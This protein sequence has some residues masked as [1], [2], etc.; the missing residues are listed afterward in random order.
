MITNH[1][2][3]GKAFDSNVEKEDTAYFIQKLTSLFTEDFKNQ[4]L[5]EYF[6][7]T[8]KFVELE[9]DFTVR[10]KSNDK[11]ELNMGYKERIGIAQMAEEYNNQIIHVRVF[12]EQ[13]EPWE[14]L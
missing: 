14:R 9:T 7:K 8:L 3:N 13:P 6:Y 1:R 4:T 12:N 2:S 5:K 11:L 10:V